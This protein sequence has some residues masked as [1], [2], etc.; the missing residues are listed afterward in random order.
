[1]G[2]V[3]D[4]TWPTSLDVPVDKVLNGALEAK[5]TDVVLVGNTEDG[6][7]YVARSNAKI[8]DSNFLLDIGK[9]ILILETMEGDEY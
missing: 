6:R 4:Q 2:E 8:A 3:I 1:M 5:L 7:V 9:H